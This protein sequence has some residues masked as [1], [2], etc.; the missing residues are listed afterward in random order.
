MNNRTLQTL[1]ALKWNPFSPEIPTEA[2]WVSPRLE[3]FCSRLQHQVREGGFALI[4]GEPGSGKSAALRLTAQRLGALPDVSVGVLSRPQSHLADFYR[5]LGH[6]FGVPLAPHN[7]WAGSKCLRQKWSAHLDQT[8]HRPLLLIDEAQEM[9]PLVLSELRLL[10]STDFDSRCLLTVV[11]CGDTR[12]L[13]LLRTESLLPVA[14]RIRARLLLETL[15]ARD[16]LDCLKH[17]LDGAGNPHLLTAELM[18]TLCEHALGNPRVL[19]QMADDLL[20]AASQRQIDRIDEKLYLELFAP[21][22]DARARP[23]TRA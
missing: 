6:L 12:L 18:N 21:P 9:H 7:R 22:N 11:L 4:S 15:P 14:S 10:A 19:M 20:L 1:Y 8:L 2:L 13:A 23:R 3:L 5:E 17:C 16:L